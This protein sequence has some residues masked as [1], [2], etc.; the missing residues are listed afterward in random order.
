MAIDNG[1]S[2]KLFAISITNPDDDKIIDVLRPGAVEM[3]SE[4]KL[5][6]TESQISME[7]L[8]C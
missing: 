5:H 6:K 3:L 4:A 2:V 1:N 7:E 8:T